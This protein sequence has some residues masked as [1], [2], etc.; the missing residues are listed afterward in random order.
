MRTKIIIAVLALAALMLSACGSSGGSSGGGGG[1]INLGLMTALTSPTGLTT[2]GDV[3]AGEQTAIHAI[4]AAGGVNGKKLHLDSCDTQTDPNQELTCA[5]KIVAKDIACLYCAT[6][7]TTPVTYFN[8]KKFPDVGSTHPGATVAQLNA[9]NQFLLTKTYGSERTFQPAQVA[10]IAKIYGLKNIALAVTD[11]SSA[12]GIQVEGSALSDLYAKKGL[13]LVKTVKFPLSTTDFT[14]YMGALKQSGAQVIEEIATEK[15]ALQLAQ[16]A[17]SLAFTG[18]IVAL[19]DGLLPPDLRQL[20]GTKAVVTQSSA[21]PPLSSGGTI[22][23]IATFLKDVAAARKAGIK[24][25]AQNDLSARML[26]GWADVEV[27]AK[28]LATTK[29]NATAASLLTALSTLKK[30][31][32]LGGVIPGGWNPK[33]LSDFQF[34]EVAKGGEW[35]LLKPGAVCTGL[36]GCGSVPFGGMAS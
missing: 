6:H 4:N 22:P 17:D 30:P 29:G 19:G 5:R 1:T 34:L 12:T 32:D 9:P 28:V 8:D 21:V 25:P 2:Y 36:D 15:G 24:L 27:V 16:S 26:E 23:G 14:P 31:V 20:S 35:T 18:P 7:S 10:A 11:L 13:K 33:K 3:L